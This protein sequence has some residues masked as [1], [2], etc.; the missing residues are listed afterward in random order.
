MHVDV[1]LPLMRADVQHSITA[2]DY[3]GW[4]RIWFLTL[5]AGSRLIRAG[6][7]KSGCASLLFA[8]SLAAYSQSSHEYELK[9]GFMYNFAQFTEWPKSAFA[10]SNSPIVI[11]VLGDEP[12]ERFIDANVRGKKIGGRRLVVES[13]PRAEDV[14]TCHI[15]FISQSEIRQ[16]DEIVKSL[17]GKPI[18]TVTDAQGPV[19][20]GV[21]IRFTTERNKFHFHINQQAAKAA[22]LTLSS[23]LLRLAG[24][25]PPTKKP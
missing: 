22:D 10:T 20:A 23:R 12:F 2:F 16:M 5:D 8:L 15:L 3:N 18:L 25:R 14:K 6:R 21:V 7:L 17:K 24:G 9:A 11:A 13:Y 19:F 1:A 4:G